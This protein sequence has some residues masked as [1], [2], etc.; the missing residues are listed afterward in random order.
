MSEPSIM[1]LT[2]ALDVG[3]AQRQL[4]ELAAGLHRRGWSITVVTFYGGGALEG[5]LRQTGVSIHCLEKHGRWDVLRFTLRLVRFIRCQQPSLVHGYLNL[6]NVLLVLLHPW[7]RRTP[8]VWGVAASNM[9]LRYYDWLARV[10]FRL[11]V[12]FSRFCQLIICNSAA[13]R[14]YHIQ[15]GYPCDRMV[16][17]PNG[18]DIEQFRP[19]KR[20]R[21]DLRTEWGIKPDEKLIGV[22][23]RLDPMKDHATFLRA[24]AQVAATRADARFVCIG[25]GPSAYRDQLAYLSRSLELDR[26]LIW[27]GER[28]DMW[29]VYNALD[30]AVSSSI[31]EGLPNVI[32][33]AMA[34][35]LPC[36]V[37]DVG[38]S[39]ALVGDLGWV[40]SPND[41]RALSQAMMRALNSLPCDRSA[42]RRRIC[43]HYSSAAL[44]ERTATEL[45]RL[46]G[47]KV[48][49][50]ERTQ[51]VPLYPLKTSVGARPQDRRNRRGARPL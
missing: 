34:T 17:I 2:R 5:Q 45:C 19:N 35:G 30:L 42:I 48:S 10:E 37:T 26:R 6:P 18:I 36:V 33:E 14:A 44:V 15:R 28:G 8:V 4:V 50:K 3:G 47:D 23:G 1:F 25:N 32:A 31:S 43:A 24:A 16:V 9:D 51:Q 13:G 29:R 11:G 7:F 21:D 27:A 46:I 12:L 20:A 40:C 41:S 49:A 39:A 38:D 22:V